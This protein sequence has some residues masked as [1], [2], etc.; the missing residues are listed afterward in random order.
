MT[1]GIRGSRG[2]RSCD[3]GREIVRTDGRG[4]GGKPLR[5][6][7]PF[8]R[9]EA[10]TIPTSERPPLVRTDFSDDAAWQEIRVSILTVPDELQDAIGLMN[11]MNDVDED[12][13][14]DEPW[15]VDI[16]DELRFADLS[17]E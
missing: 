6:I 1:N 7:Y 8:E 2:Q 5:T 16:I 10:M 17:T 12:D 3:L 14:S 13:V 15:F 9:G 11:F 4:R